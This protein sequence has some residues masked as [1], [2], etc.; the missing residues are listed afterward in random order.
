MPKAPGISVVIPM[1]N[2]ERTIAVPLSSLAH[3]TLPPESFELVLVDDGSTDR[4]SSKARKLLEPVPYRWE[5]LEGARKG[6]STARNKG[7]DHAL[8]DHVFFLDADD[9]LPP[10]FLATV[11]EGIEKD[12]AD[13]AWIWKITNPAEFPALRKH[14]IALKQSGV[15]CLEAY[16]GIP[17][18]AQVMVRRS[19][20]GSSR[21]RYTEG[22]AYGEDF[23]FFV[24]LLLEARRVHVEDRT[25]YL[26]RRHA[27]QVTRTIDRLEARKATDE[28]F[29]RLSGF[30]EGKGAPR[31][32]LFEMKRNEA[33][34]RI[35]L[36]REAWKRR[37]EGYFDALL[38]SPE[39]DEAIRFAGQGKL[40]VKWQM[41]AALLDLARMVKG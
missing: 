41:R 36:L 18:N 11:L 17:R 1:Y 15:D 4:S 25:F 19:F 6:V 10:D 21:V 29:R 9:S 28:A 40:S 38:E 34:A 8:G 5:I 13:L 12:G 7:I 24:R 26:Y 35:N 39:T 27:F 23:D 31:E 37:P 2:A 30:L 33:R 16:L 20:L 14:P 32:I 22:L 3:Q